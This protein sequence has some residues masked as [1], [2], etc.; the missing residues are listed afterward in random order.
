M[1][2][3]KS[4]LKSKRVK[5]FCKVAC[6]VAVWG[7]ASEITA[8]RPTMKAATAEDPV[9]HVRS[10]TVSPGRVYERNNFTSISRESCSLRYDVFAPSSLT[11]SRPSF[12]K[13]KQVNPLARKGSSNRTPATG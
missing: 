4:F 3:G 13:E 8:L 10:I 9:P 6:A 5:E 1:G 11:F 12:A 7:S 2:D